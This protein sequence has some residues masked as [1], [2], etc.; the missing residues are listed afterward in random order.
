[1]C[2]YYIWSSFTACREQQFDRVFFYTFTTLPRMQTVLQ[3]YQDSGF[4]DVLPFTL[5]GSRPS[6]N[7]LWEKMYIDGRTTELDVYHMLSAYDCI[8]R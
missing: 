5:P 7:L 1:M 2:Y 8:Y 3:H 6:G 4:V